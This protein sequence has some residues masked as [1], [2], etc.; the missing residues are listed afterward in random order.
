MKEGLSP[1]AIESV[2]S[3]KVSVLQ[4]RPLLCNVALISSYLILEDYLEAVGDIEDSNRV[5][6]ELARGEVNAEIE[7]SQEHFQNAGKWG[8]CCTS[9][10]IETLQIFLFHF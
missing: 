10:I 2:K 9:P 4:L 8:L 1:A 3:V 5:G 6:R 7:S